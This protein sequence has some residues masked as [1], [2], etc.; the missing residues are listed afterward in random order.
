MDAG[1]LQPL[2]IGAA[3]NAAL[4]DHRELRG[5]PLSQ[6]NAVP[7]VRRHRLEVPVVHTDQRRTQTQDT[8]EVRRF[9]EL[10]EALHSQ[11]ARIAVQVGQFRIVQALG[12]QEDRIGTGRAGFEH[13]V[14]VDDKVLPQ[15]RQV[16]HRPD[17]LQVLQRPLKV[18][19]IGQHRHAR[20]PVLG[21]R[22]G[23]R[24]RIE[25]GAD[26]PRRRRGLLH[27]GDQ[28]QRMAGLESP[29]E[30]PDGGSIGQS[31][32]ECRRGDGGPAL[33]DLGPRVSD[34]LLQNVRHR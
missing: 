3:V 23:D 18:P 34:D 10:D 6:L 19:L 22:P 8:L 15:H 4:S 7:E 25:V 27:L 20:G 17:L 9:V 16:D 31:F 1:V 5:D 12:D 11:F 24:D 14:A 29:R 30:I 21:V 33:R 28:A 2:H 32:L 13:L 26:Q